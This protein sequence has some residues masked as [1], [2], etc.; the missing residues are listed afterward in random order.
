MVLT[1]GLDGLKGDISGLRGDI[2]KLLGEISSLRHRIK[3]AAPAPRRASSPESARS[4]SVARGRLA[5]CRCTADA[6]RAL[7]EIVV[8]LLGCEELVVFVR[9]ADADGGAANAPA[10]GRDLVL[11]PAFTMGVS[12][13]PPALRPLPEGPLDAALRSGAVRI[14]DGTLLDFVPG[15]TRRPAAWAPLRSGD[16]VV[17]AIALF[18]LLPQK[19][20]LSES[21]LALLELLVRLGGAALDRAVAA[22]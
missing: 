14:D 5:A 16:V 1:T 4:L 22:S 8:D 21:D 12:P 10:L 18:G 2:A 19:P 6:V 7:R 17:G 13:E 15:M 3:S 11:V 20:A 9:A